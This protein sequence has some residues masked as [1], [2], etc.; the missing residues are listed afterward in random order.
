[1]ADGST[2][3]AMAAIITRM[4]AQTLYVPTPAI[5]KPGSVWVELPRLVAVGAETDIER[6]AVKGI[7]SCGLVPLTLSWQRR[8]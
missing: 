5:R 4:I 6:F 1:M 2:W 8:V 3:P 7:L